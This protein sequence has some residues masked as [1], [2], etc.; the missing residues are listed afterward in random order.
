MY[1]DQ[2]RGGGAILS[3]YATYEQTFL[4]KIIVCG[5]NLRR[6]SAEGR[7]NLRGVYVQNNI[8]TGDKGTDHRS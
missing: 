8:N 1:E 2:R 6:G 3:S 7:Y 5:L 4:I